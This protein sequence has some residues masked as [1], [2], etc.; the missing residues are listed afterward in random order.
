MN[1]VTE[2]AEK[3]AADIKAGGDPEELLEK[4]RADLQAIA[5]TEIADA[6]FDTGTQMLME[7]GLDSVCNLIED[8]LI[9]EFKVLAGPVQDDSRQYVNALMQM[10]PLIQFFTTA[11]R[12]Q[13]RG[14][15]EFQ[16][17]TRS[18]KSFYDSMLKL[19]ELKE[20]AKLESM[21]SSA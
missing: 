14:M 16:A 13:A 8:L 12:A 18:L 7:D 15:P 3:I 6:M 11:A 1:K 10:Q 2:I 5:P 17:G 9:A 21:E 19:A 4:G 20:K